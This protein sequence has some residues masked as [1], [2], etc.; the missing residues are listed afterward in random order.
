MVASLA[1]FFISKLDLFHQFGLHSRSNIIASCDVILD[2]KSNYFLIRDI[3]PMQSPV[4][5]WEFFNLISLDESGMSTSFSWIVMKEW[6]F[7]PLIE[8]KDQTR[9]I[10]NLLLSEFC[11]VLI[12][13][14]RNQFLMFGES[15][16]SIFRTDLFLKNGSIHLII[17]DVFC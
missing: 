9:E 11:S 14:I 7:S 5:W 8:L 17:Q 10:E 1:C 16:L 12:M 13:C 15:L 3:Q 6:Y 2:V 4:Q